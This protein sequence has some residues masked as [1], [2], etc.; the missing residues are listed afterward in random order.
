MNL[1]HRIEAMNDDL[2]RVANVSF[3]M[4]NMLVLLEWVKDK[5]GHLSCPSCN[6]PKDHGHGSECELAK[7]LCESKDILEWAK[8]EDAYNKKIEKIRRSAVSS[9]MQNIE[10]R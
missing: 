7:L 1:H 8:P 3:R 9:E 4:A 6:M 5:S 10:S 2:E